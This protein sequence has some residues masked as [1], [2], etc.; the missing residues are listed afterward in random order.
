MKIAIEGQRLFRKKKHGMDFVALELIRNLQK[1]DKENEYYVFVKPDEDVCLQDTEN[2]RIIHLDG[3]SY[4]VWEQK[5]LP[6]AVKKYGCQ[7]LHCTSNT[8]PVTKEF[9]L[10]VH[11]HDIIYLEKL[12]L[13][14]K[15]GTLYQKM[16]NLYR[17]WNVP[18]VMNLA[19]KVITVSEF[20]RETIVSRFP[21]LAHKV[22][23]I[24]NGVSEHFRPVEHEEARAICD[25]YGLPGEYLFYLGN[26]D[27]KKNT[28][29]TLKAYALYRRK[30]DNPLPLVMIDFG[31][32][33]FNKIL[34]DIGEPD[35]KQHIHLSD[36]I[37]NIDLPAIYSCSTAFLYPSLRESF[38]I[39]LLEG[40]RCGTPVITA[41]TSSMPEVSGDAAIQCDPENPEEIA[42]AIYQVTTSPVLRNGL[43]ER[44]FK[45]AAQFSW[46]K[47][48]R[49][50]LA[51]YRETL[52][53]QKP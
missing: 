6:A 16:G 40:M 22:I 11:V 47:M 43:I 44:G 51:V 10:V 1:I 42:D 50:V 34:N 3:G 12:M 23:A 7:L 26:T 18:R 45:R 32:E 29:N 28:P 13:F 9:P 2:F 33:A 37:R 27:P 39:P 46:E 38:G 8:A 21:E 4:P 35:L 20:E 15:G 5:S 31:K 14:Q 17:R 49:E 30:S 24:Y 25:R 19:E 52:K 48:A 36:Y 41:N 53:N